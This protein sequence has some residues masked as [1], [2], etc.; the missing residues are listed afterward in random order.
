[1]RLAFLS[2]L[3]LFAVA[4]CRENSSQSSAKFEILSSDIKSWSKTPDLIAVVIHDNAIEK[5]SLIQEDSPDK[6]INIYLNGEFLMSPIVRER[7]PLS[8]F[9]FAI[10]NDK[11]F[12]EKLI[13]LLPAEKKTQ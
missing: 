1:M 13:R 6:V 2:F 7:G 8:S 4:A 5:F 3:L 10:Q 12:E 11:A 9:Y